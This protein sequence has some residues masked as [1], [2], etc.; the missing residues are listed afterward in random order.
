M[1]VADIMT[2]HPVSVKPTDRLG[3]VAKQITDRHISGVFVTDGGRLIGQISHK[4]VLKRIFP[5]YEEF[6]DDL[7]HNVDFEQIQSRA[8]EMADL[9]AADVMT[10]AVETI[11]PDVPVMKVAS[12][13]LLKDVHRLAVVD[14]SDKLIGVVS[15]GDVFYKTI[16]REMNGQEPDTAA[17]VKSARTAA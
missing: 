2:T 13:M 15:R 5:T 16:E 4:D 17:A 11:G 10:T 7:T 8:R 12:W 6:Y 3:D 9:T 14:A 1:K